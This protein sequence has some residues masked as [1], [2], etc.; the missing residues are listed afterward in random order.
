MSR[1]VAATVDFDD[2]WLDRMGRPDEVTAYLMCDCCGAGMERRCRADQAD[3]QMEALEFRASVLGW[4]LRKVVIPCQG[5]RDYCAACMA[6]L[7]GVPDRKPS[8]LDA[9]KLHA[10]PR[11]F[12]LV[13][14]LVVLVIVAIVAAVTLP[15]VSGWRESS[16]LDAAATLVQGEMVAAR[17]RAELRG[18]AGIRLLPDPT[19]PIVRRDDGSIDPDAVLA[20]DRI[21]PLEAGPGYTSGL[22]AVRGPS[23]G[24]PPGFTPARNRLV[25]E[26]ERL[27]AD[28]SLLEPTGWEWNVRCGDRVELLGRSYTVCGPVAVG[29]AGGNAELFVNYA[30]AWPALDRGDGAVEWLYLVDGLDDDGDGYVDNGRNGLDDDGDGHVDGE[31]EWSEEERWGPGADGLRRAS[32][33]IH[34][35]PV[36]APGS[37]GVALA[38]V[39]IDA[40]GW[41]SAVAPRSA[42][43]VDPWTGAA[44]LLFDGSG[45]VEPAR[46]VATPTSIRW[47]HLWI[48]P[49]EA[50]GLDVPA[51]TGRLVSIDAKTGRASA[52]D[53]DPADPAASRRAMEGGGL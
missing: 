45:R 34:R 5:E 36:P 1:H 17:A 40:T 31:S 33:V 4:K 13:E 42:I 3:D 6:G 14:L 47:H 10:I 26:G 49:R 21:A 41:Q 12:T 50:V 2:G 27:A 39:V 11:G 9:A 51:A 7:R 48:T 38:G 30:P 37:T 46:A 35:R 32:Y 8:V 44:D 43:V 15:A 23:E 29:P 19:F 18:A 20:Y 24:Y 22:V 52:G 25:L 28:G 16:R 53:A